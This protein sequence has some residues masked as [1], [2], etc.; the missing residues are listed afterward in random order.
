M[1]NEVDNTNSLSNNTVLS[2]IQDS[3][4]NMWVGVSRRGF[5]IW[6]SRTERF[7]HY[8]RIDNNENS[9]LNNGIRG[10]LKDHQDQLW[11]ATYGGISVIKENGEIRH[12]KH[13]PNDPT[14][15][16]S[17][18]VTSIYQDRQQRIWIGTV[19]GLNL[20]HLDTDSFTRFQ[21]DELDTYSLSHDHVFCIFQ[22]NQDRLWIGTDLGG[23][24]EFNTETG[25]FYR[26][27]FD[28]RSA[29]STNHFR[30]KCMIQDSLDQIWVGTDLGLNLFNPKSGTFQYYQH[31]VG[32]PGSL[33]NNTIRS[34]AMDQAGR[35]FIGTDGGVNLFDPKTQTFR[36]WR[37]NDGLS[38]DV[39]YIILFDDHN[40]MWISTNKGINKVNLE[41][42]KVIF[43]DRQDGLQSDEFNNAAGFK[44]RNGFMYFGGV[45]G[46]SYFHPDSLREDESIPKVVITDF[47]LFNEYVSINDSS[48][49]RQS[50]NYTDR[51][52]L[53]Y[54]E[55]IFAFEFAGLHYEQPSKIEYAFKLDPFHNDWIY[56]DATDRKAGFTRIPA[57]DY[58]FQVKASSIS[59]LWNEASTK[60]NVTIVPAWYQTGWAK[61]LLALLILAV[62]GLVI[63]AR[64]RNAKRIRQEL[65]AMVE[66]KTE[67]LRAEK[68]EVSKQ[69]AEKEILMQEVHHR[70]KNNLTFLKSLLYL[71]G[72]ASDDKEVRRILDECQARIQSVA[73]VH[74]NLYDV[75]DTTKVNFKIFLDELFIELFGLFEGDLSHIEFLMKVENI[76]IDMKTSVFLG[77]II[78]ELITNSFKYAF[79]GEDGLIE[80]ELTESQDRYE[81]NY[82]DN[83]KGFPEDFQYATSSGFGFRLIN[84]LLKQLNAQM[85]QEKT[86]FNIVIAK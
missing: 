37:D 51:V 68:E 8:R 72:K 80:V 28:G 65:E 76:K 2:M 73:L 29:R 40:A 7:K 58:T 78:N 1:V 22:D 30:I 66:N 69:L 77:L 21:R 32:N 14:S 81:L 5:N 33:S 15:L 41:S 4:D 25:K 24:N 39:A 45:N 19:Y 42:E 56:T 50:L 43:Y 52:T 85:T 34:L 9:L 12:F 20:Y 26:Y 17:N 31:E 16:S 27:A 86:I 18:Q 23:L 10:I 82:A 61:G 79:D 47:S 53:N 44:D 83:G 11:V 67:L 3:R 71:R 84:I 38:N 74:Q 55:D 62:I 48:I 54:D 57:G 49:L 35:V 64:E 6:N 70:V 59:G 63:Q 60:L 36:H 13:D 46:L 75:E